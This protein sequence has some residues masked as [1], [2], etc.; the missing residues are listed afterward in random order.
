MNN[1]KENFQIYKN[2]FFQKTKKQQKS[3]AKKKKKR[4]KGEKGQTFL[5]RKFLIWKCK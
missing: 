3:R 4:G 5:F 1:F 2:K